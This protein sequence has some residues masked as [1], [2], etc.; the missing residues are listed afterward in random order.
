MLSAFQLELPEGCSCTKCSI[1]SCRRYAAAAAA[2]SMCLLP[3]SSAGGGKLRSEVKSPHGDD[4]RSY[5]LLEFDELLLICLLGEIL[6][7]AVRSF[8]REVDVKLFTQAE[9]AA[10][11]N[12]ACQRVGFHGVCCCKFRC[13]H[14]YTRRFLLYQ[15][16]GVPAL[17]YPLAHHPIGLGFR[18]PEAL[19]GC[20]LFHV[21]CSVSSG[22]LWVQPN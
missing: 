16:L 2:A 15:F 20:V 17:R 11:C 5:L 13:Q 6:A 3:P 7:L 8:R 21:I 14:C 22:R 9:S 1:S 12:R 19:H 18:M 10:L 4:L